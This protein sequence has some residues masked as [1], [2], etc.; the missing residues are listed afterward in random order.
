MCTLCSATRS[1][2]PRRH[3]DG[4]IDFD[5]PFSNII[6]ETQDALSDPGT[7]YGM[8]P[9]DVF[10]GSIDSTYD[11][12]WVSIDLTAGTTY[13]LAMKGTTLEGPL[14]SLFS[15]QGQQLSFD[16]DSDTL[17]FFTPKTSGTYYLAASGQDLGGYQMGVREV[18]QP[19]VPDSTAA[20]PPG[21]S[22][23]SSPT[24]SDQAPSGNGTL[25]QMA[26]FLIS[27]YWGSARRW[28]VSQDNIISV[29]L[30]TLDS[31][32]RTLARWALE[33]WESV[34]NLRFTETRGAAN[35]T[36]DDEQSGAWAS[37][38]FTNQGYITSSTINISKTWIFG[39]VADISSYAFSTY[40]HELGHAL[41]V[42]HMGRYNGSA[43]FSR[44]AV[45]NNDSYQLSVMSYF[46]QTE[47]PN[48]NASYGDPITPMMADI[49]AMQRHYGAANASTS[50]TAGAT[51]WGKNGTLG[52]YMD[53]FFDQD[54]LSS[55]SAMTIYDVG[56][57]DK[58]DLSHDNNHTRLDLRPEGIS[59]VGGRTGNLMIARGTQIENLVLGG[60]NDTVS[61]NNLS[62][63][64]V[65]N[66][67]NDLV[68]D[69]GGWDRIW[70]GRGNDTAYGGRGND[71]IG[72]DAGAD[73]IWGGSGND[74]IWGGGW[75]DEVGGGSG[76]DRLYGDNGNDTV[77]G[78][79]GH[80]TLW[81]GQ[82]DDLLSGGSGN[83]RFYG[84][85]GQDT[86]RGGSGND[87]LDGG[88][89]HDNLDGGSGNDTL[90]GGAGNDTLF[91]SSGNDSVDGGSGNDTLWVGMG[92]DDLTGGL[93][94]DT[95]IF[96]RGAQNNS[97][98]DFNLGQGDK[99]R[100]NDAIWQGDHGSLNASQVVAQFA[101][102]QGNDVLLR[103][104]S[105]TS[106]LLE[107]LGSLAGL[108]SAIEI[109]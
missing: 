41:G 52:T 12:D 85:D 39:G 26:D 32:G 84:E 35:I 73:V 72:G 64:I 42:G 106:V 66:D 17:I 77:W 10:S 3:A 57:I 90:W 67:G 70:L 59:D 28:D 31:A 1:F 89:G 102:L 101:T 29:N 49:V 91:G 47:N 81:G 108:S 94:A 8:N 5:N 54:S 68:R 88:T 53:R 97:I 9:G 80:D 56:G 104:D 109:F 19:P 27:G 25:D 37:S 51:V 34:V 75:G 78:G 7:V 96:G 74:T 40:I 60:G 21:Y 45:F 4:T 103:F 93:G 46:S 79:S 107:D 44:D 38:S 22:G 100:L 95:F 92:S 36:F 86:L 69:D 48:V 71:K 61:A 83:D 87:M 30:S 16:E 24:S 14:L 33:A 20:N 55:R 82:H 2:D 43:S 23:P 58:L 15:E 76:D 105:Q 63:L 65:T 99:L 18:A 6:S 11:Q 62:N 50:H 98:S 13:E